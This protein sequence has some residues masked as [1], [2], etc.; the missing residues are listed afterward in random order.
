MICNLILLNYLI[1]NNV[2][3]NGKN[4]QLIINHINNLSNNKGIFFEQNENGNNFLK[5]LVK[6]AIKLNNI[7]LLINY[8]ELD[9]LFKNDRRYD[10]A[11]NCL[12]EYEFNSTCIYN[13]LYPKKVIGKTRKLF[14]GRNSA[15]YVLLNEFDDIKIAYSFGIGNKTFKIFFDK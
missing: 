5:K 2:K 4:T 12:A 1:N 10:G 3:S 15:G 9:K 13:Y 8:L 11:R 14:G 6:K 7:F